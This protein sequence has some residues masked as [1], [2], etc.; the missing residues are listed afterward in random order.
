VYLNCFRCS[1]NT[2]IT[3]KEFPG[4]CQLQSQ[5]GC[6]IVL[7]VVTDFFGTLHLFL[8]QVGLERLLL[9]QAWNLGNKV[10]LAVAFIAFQC[11]LERG[12]SPVGDKRRHLQ[13]EVA[14]VEKVT[15]SVE[16][17]DRH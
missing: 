13:L 11:L 12:E 7:Q 15:L 10:P 5:F 9:D 16:V 8:Q 3:K 6:L 2:E 14:N 17:G 1:S 4:V